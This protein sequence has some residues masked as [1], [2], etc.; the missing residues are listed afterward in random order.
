MPEEASKSPVTQAPAVAPVTDQKKPTSFREELA[1]KW[2]PGTPLPKKM[3]DEIA[4]HW[5]V[6][7]AAIYKARKG[8]IKIEE[9][10]TAIEISVEKPSANAL[11]VEVEATR[12]PGPPISPGGTGGS[13]ASL[14][15]IQFEP[16]AGKEIAPIFETA[17][18][19][20]ETAGIAK[21]EELPEKSITDQ[22]G[23]LWASVFNAFQIKKGEASGK[24]LVLASAG[25][26]TFA[27]YG[28]FMLKALKKKDN[29]E[30]KPE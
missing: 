24:Y 23:D 15:S 26:S 29:A 11:K 22:L 16:W 3:A 10:V 14:P 7:P 6:S 1:Q 28:P 13:S 2:T 19:L 4:H 18:F 5:N 12:K 30:K 25:T 21:K 20:I 27:V 17:G 8:L 9:K